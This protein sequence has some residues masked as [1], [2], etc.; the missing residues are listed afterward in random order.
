MGRPEAMVGGRNILYSRRISA[1]D[2]VIYEIYDDRILV[3]VILI[4]G[5][6]SDK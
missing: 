3:L 2:R 5:H 1:H 4:Q 6:Y